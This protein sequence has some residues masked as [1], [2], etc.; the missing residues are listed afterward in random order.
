MGAL[1]AEVE[2]CVGNAGKAVTK[3]VKDIGEGA[4]E[5]A[6]KAADTF[7]GLFKK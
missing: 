2:Q 5:G 3:G 7:K 6:T 1:L 4:K